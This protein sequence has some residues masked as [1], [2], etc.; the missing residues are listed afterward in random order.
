MNLDSE[1][2]RC[3]SD[4]LYFIELLT[5]EVIPY[6]IWWNTSIVFDSIGQLRE[7]RER[8]GEGEGEDWSEGAAGE[9]GD[10]CLVACPEVG[11]GE[12]CGW[13]AVITLGGV[14]Y[15]N[16]SST[17]GGVLGEGKREDGEK[18]EGGD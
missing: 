10:N 4:L 11:A 13:Y 1:S 15:A 2:T 18:G 6:F 5:H 3:E 12:P 9:S 17:Y 14:D 7:A 16:T 8:W